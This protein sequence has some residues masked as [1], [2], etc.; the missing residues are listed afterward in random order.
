MAPPCCVQ[1]TT[2]ITFIFVK[3]KILAGEH[4][5]VIVLVLK[6]ENMNQIGVQ[7]NTVSSLNKFVKSCF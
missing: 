1:L 4:I 3:L 5:C 7:Y 2:L 6:C